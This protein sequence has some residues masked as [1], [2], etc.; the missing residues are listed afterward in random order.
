MRILKAAG[1][2][3]AL[4]ALVGCTSGSVKNRIIPE[5]EKTLKEVYSDKINV[6]ASIEGLTAL[7]RKPTQEELGFDPYLQTG[8]DK[9]K[10][11]K[12]PNP[13]LFIYFPPSVSGDSRM[14]TPGWMTEIKMYDRDEY[15][16]PGESYVGGQ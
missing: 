15:A 6:S 3:L 4:F 10:Y 11:R 16:L 14:P 8:A 7:K 2:V 13:T 5:S 9:V 12:I 1:I